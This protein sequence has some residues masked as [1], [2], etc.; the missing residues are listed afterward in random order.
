MFFSF[1]VVWLGL[2]EF[3]LD[4]FLVL[5]REILLLYLFECLVC[6]INATI[7]VHSIQ[8]AKKI[9][10]LI[11]FLYVIYTSLCTCASFENKMIYNLQYR[12]L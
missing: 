4:S 8:N 1:D 6:F 9:C 12:L 10:Q 3:V 7:Y 2:V 5:E 11:Y